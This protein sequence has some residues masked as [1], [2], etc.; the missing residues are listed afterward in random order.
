MT[1]R[2]RRYVGRKISQALKRGAK[3]GNIDRDALRFARGLRP[4]S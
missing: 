1:D 3:R 4:R 2:A